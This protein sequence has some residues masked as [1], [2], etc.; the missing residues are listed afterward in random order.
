MHRLEPQSLYVL[1][2][3]ILIE[4]TGIATPIAIIAIHR[5][6]VDLLLYP[7]IS[8][9]FGLSGLYRIVT[10]CPSL[11]FDDWSQFRM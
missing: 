4:H 3:T 1:F 2:H 6:I 9:C 10:A 11:V 8:I 7:S 5:Y